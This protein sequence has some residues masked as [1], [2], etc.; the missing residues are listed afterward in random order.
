M[1]IPSLSAVAIGVLCTLNTVSAA[2]NYEISWDAAYKKAEALVGQMSLE[3]KVNV[4]TGVG[5]GNGLC[6]GNTFGTTNPDF[7]SLCLQDGPLG[8][9]K[10]KS[11]ISMLEILIYPFF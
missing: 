1:H 3:Q 7:P 11:T 2:K 4:T 10:E 9:N 8:K 5:W 6:V